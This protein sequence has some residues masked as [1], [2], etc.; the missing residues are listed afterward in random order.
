VGLEC[1]AGDGVSIEQQFAEVAESQR[2]KLCS[3]AYRYLRNMEDS[4][5]A[6]QD[7]LLNAHRNLH[8]WRGEA[9]LSTWLGSIV[10]RSCLMK[11]R[12]QRIRV[13]EET[14][15]LVFL[16]LEHPGLNPE[17]ILCRDQIMQ[18]LQRAIGLLSPTLRETVECWMD[19]RTLQDVAREL[20]CPLGTV[21][22]RLSRARVRISQLVYV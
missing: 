9:S 5:E 21:K 17:E 4:E 11:K 1:G 22:A 6:V 3:I 16:R 18:K 8:Q 20:D 7:A 13:D 14:E 19:G 15:R 10:V 12:G 2:G